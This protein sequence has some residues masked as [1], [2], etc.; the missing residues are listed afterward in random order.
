MLKP[1]TLNLK[2]LP[3]SCTNAPTLH[4]SFNIFFWCLYLAIHAARI[5]HMCT[6][7]FY[8]D[9]HMML[10]PSRPLESLSQSTLYAKT[11]MNRWS[12]SKWFS[13]LEETKGTGALGR[14]WKVI[15]SN[16]LSQQ[17]FKGT[18]CAQG[19]ADGHDVAPTCHVTSGRD[20]R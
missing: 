7:C 15:V 18:I 17:K 2:P 11:S 10:Q 13:L 5:S 12:C 19:C 3:K 20:A 4:F 14:G 9:P 16:L 8:W 6:T 1:Y